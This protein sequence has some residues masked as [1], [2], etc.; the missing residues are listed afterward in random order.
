MR[1]SRWLPEVIYSQCH[2][3][4]ILK[5]RSFAEHCLADWNSKHSMIYIQNLAQHQLSRSF[6]TSTISAFF[7]CSPLSV[8]YHP[9]AWRSNKRGS[10]IGSRASVISSKR[11]FSIPRASRSPFSVSSSCIRQCYEWKSLRI[12]GSPSQISLIRISPVSA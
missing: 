11:L 7:W 1:R 3:R 2:P 6:Y 5:Q 12:R 10:Q 9:F 8:G 4:L